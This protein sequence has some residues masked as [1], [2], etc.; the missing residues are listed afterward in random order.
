MQILLMRQR[1]GRCGSTTPIWSA[2]CSGCGEILVSPRQLRRAGVLYLVL[3]SLITFPGLYMIAWVAVIM[4]RS[5][6]PEATTRFTGDAWDAV[7][8]FAFLGFVLTVG[9]VGLLM[10]AWQVKYGR[11]NLRLVS[12]VIVL[13]VIFWTGAVLVQVLS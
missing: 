3:G 6:D 7:L 10:G 2:V 12:V 13:N 8:V 4:A 5:D 9:I 1:C 11:R